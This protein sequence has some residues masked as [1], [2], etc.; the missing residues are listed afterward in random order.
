MAAVGPLPLPRHTAC[1]QCGRM[2]RCFSLFPCGRDALV[3]L[4]HAI[5]A[6]N[7]LNYRVFRMACTIRVPPQDTSAAAGDIAPP[8]GHQDTSAAAAGDI[9][10]PPGELHQPGLQQPGLHQPG[11]HQPGLHQ[12]GLHPPGL[13]YHQE[14]LVRLLHRLL[15]EQPAH[16]HDALA[17]DLRAPSQQQL[18]DAFQRLS[19]TNLLDQHLRLQELLRGDPDD[20]ELNRWFDRL[21]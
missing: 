21:D 11:L 5:D 15:E 12:P 8:A 16:P 13:F 20:D 6:G 7:A 4:G 9:A 3:V 10:P 14:Q 2:A 1:P 17:D 19:E 18:A